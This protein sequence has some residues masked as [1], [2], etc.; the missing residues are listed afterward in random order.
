VQARRLK[1]RLWV[2]VPC[3][4]TSG[5]ISGPNA[6]TMERDGQRTLRDALLFVIGDGSS[7][8]KESLIARQM[9]L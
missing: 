4:V 5:D 8:M 6:F 1:C 9:G 7:E 2:L 3:F